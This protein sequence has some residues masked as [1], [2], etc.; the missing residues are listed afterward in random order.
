MYTYRLEAEG[1]TTFVVVFKYGLGGFSLPV[2][3]QFKMVL[4]KVKGS[5]VGAVETI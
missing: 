2:E 4:L 5:V 1:N 3:V